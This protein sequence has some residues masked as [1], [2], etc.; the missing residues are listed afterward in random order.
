MSNEP[1]RNHNLP[2]DPIPNLIVPPQQ[3]RP[4]IPISDISASMMVSSTVGATTTAAAAVTGD[5]RATNSTLP[6]YKDQS[7]SFLRPTNHR[8]NHR[9]NSNNNNN[10]TNRN[11]DRKNPHSSSNI[12]GT[13]TTSMTQPE[14]TVP[15]AEA[16][17]YPESDADFVAAAYDVHGIGRAAHPNTSIDKTTQPT[18]LQKKRTVGILLVTFL[19]ISAAV[20]GGVCGTGNCTSSKKNSTNRNSTTGTDDSTVQPFFDDATVLQNAVDEYMAAV[21]LA[22]NNSITNV[23]TTAVAMRYGYPMNTWDVGRVSNFS[24]MFDGKRNVLLKSTFNEDLSNWNVSSAVDM[25]RMFAT[26]DLYE[27]LG[28]EFWDVSNVKTIRGMFHEA[29]N[30]EGNIASWQVGNVESFT[31]TFSECRKFNIDIS[32]WDTSKSE[33]TAWMVRCYRCSIE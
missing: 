9:Y 20:V 26:L 27:G 32:S 17:A 23:A 4:S 24:T 19:V 3:S 31:R 16:I 14:G 30:F 2:D 6:D 18:V 21:V 7:R 28:L 11:N 10:N 15:L 8:G 5:D 25:F 1:T 22:G 33:S 12:T 29:Y 13:D